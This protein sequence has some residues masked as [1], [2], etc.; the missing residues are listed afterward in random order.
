MK[1]IVAVFV[2]FLILLASPSG[3]FTTLWQLGKED[4]NPMDFGASYTGTSTAPGSALAGDDDYYFAG[5]F[6]APILTVSANEPLPRVKRSISTWEPNTRFHFILNATQATNTLRVRVTSKWIWGGFSGGSNFGEHELRFR[7]NGN[8]IATKMIRNNK[9]IVFEANA[10]V[11][12]ANV[13]ANT[14]K[15]SRIGGSTNAWLSMDALQLDIY[16]TALVDADG[17]GLPEWWELD[18]GLSISLAD[19]NADPDG[20]G[21]TNL[22]EMGLS[23]DPRVADSDADGL[24]DGAEM[25]AGTNPLDK[26]TDDDQLL[27]GWELAQSPS[28]NPLSADSDLDGAADSWEI[29]CGFSATNASSEPPAFNA[30]IGVHFVSGMSESS[31]LL[32]NHVSGWV[33]QPFWNA[34]RPLVPWSTSSGNGADVASPTQGQLVDSSGST[35]AVTMAW[36]CGNAW[37]TG[38]QQSPLFDGYL[39]NRN[40]AD[41]TLALSNIPYTN[42][43]LVVY[44]GSNADNSIGYVRVNNQS[45]TDFYFNTGSTAPENRYLVGTS[46]NPTRP[47]R[48]NVVVFRNLT[49]SSCF[50]QWFRTSYYTIGLHGFQIINRAQD[51]D[52]DGMPDWWEFQHQ[53]HAQ[54]ASDASTDADNDGWSNLVEF[55]NGTSPRIADTDND[56]II[57]SAE[58]QSNPLLADTD[59]DGLSDGAELAVKPTATNP[60]L[61][62]TDGDGR[63]D[64][65]EVR[66]GTNPTI[67]NSTTD[68]LPVVTLSP[69]TFLWRIDN[70]QLVWNHDLSHLAA[71]EWND[72]YLFSSSI[73]NSSTPDAWSSL[74]FGIRF[75]SGKIVHFFYSSKD[76]AFS[77]ANAPANDIWESDW[78]AVT[79]LRSMLGF[80]GVGPCDISDRLRIELSGTSSGSRSAWTIT[81]RLRNLD[82]NAEVVITRNN[83]TLASNVH[84]N[85]AT[86]ENEAGVANRVNYNVNAGIAAHFQPTRLE[87]LPA[88]AAWA[89]GDNDGM[90]NSWEEQ[91]GLNAAL[92]GD[93]NLDADGDGLSNLK[94]FLAHTN[95]LLRDTDGDG[96]PDLVEVQYNSNPLLASSKPPL[97]MGAQQPTMPQDWNG[98]GIPDPW[99]FHYKSWGLA[100]QADQDGDGVS[101][102][103]ESLAGTN[104][105]DPNSKLYSRMDRNGTQFLLCWPYLAHKNATIES[106][107]SLDSGWSTITA[108]PVRNGAE[109]EALMPTSSATKNFY[110]VGVSD[111]DTDQD[112]VSDWA[113][114][115]VLG[116]SISVANSMRSNQPY[117]ANGDGIAESNV[118]GDR[119]ALLQLLEGGN[120]NGGYAGGTAG[121]ISQSNAARFL[122]QSSFGPTDEDVRMVQNLGFSGW[123][124]QQISLPPT[125]HSTYA[126]EINDD[127]FGPRVHKNY[128][129]GDTFLF[130][131]NLQ[132]A[133]ARAAIGSEDQ[134]RQR[135]AF[136]LSQILVASRRDANLE[137]RVLGMASFYDIFVRHALGNYEDILQEVA[138]HPCMGRYLSH[139]GNQKAN[140]EINQYPDENFARE[141]MQLFTIGLWKL[142]PDGTRQIGANG[143]T[144]PTYSNTDITQLARVFTGLWYSNHAWGNGGWSESDFTVPM[145]LHPDRHDFGTK[146]LLGGAIIPSRSAT[147]ENARKDIRDAISLLFQHENTAPFVSRQLIQFLVTDNPTPA[148]VQRVASVFINNGSGK[149]GDLAAV[150]RAILLDQEARDPAAAFGLSF[151]RLKEPIL[152]TMALARV[153][154]MKQHEDLLWWDWND[155]YASSRQE[156][157]YS[158]SVFN[159]YRPD[160]R[161]PGLLTQN[162]LSSPVFQITDSFSSIAFPN[163]IWKDIS[164]GFRLW[165]TY[166]FPLDLSHEVSLASNPE[167]L[168]NRLNVMFCGG[169]M[170]AAT[171][172]TILNA[173]KTIPSSQPEA[174]ARVALYLTMVSAEGAVMR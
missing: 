108:N 13:G 174:R 100:P 164:E 59:G 139:L 55:T 41:G 50:L 71:G 106:S 36:T 70:L 72:D 34:T 147:A 87:S 32:A 173:L 112:G 143:Q 21:L 95:P 90:T 28:L 171:R 64:A 3:A 135:V 137:N 169:H 15:V 7:I 132:T 166:Q 165:G 168:L 47:Q 104:P 60:Q 99:E 149:R 172:S 25:T 78:G 8:T 11:F 150:V 67:A 120:A 66:D 5:N 88:F 29:K 76:G 145:G 57:D 23:T 136:A 97:S 38:N 133:F 51:G 103:N 61:T 92:A 155:Y 79:D 119:V 73:V 142:N 144:I 24:H 131:N 122:I 89:D 20:D 114:I 129:Y 163:R 56:G 49:G 35:T 113:E 127:F 31:A 6:P 54:N 62:D 105:F 22:Q 123:I 53:L 148:Y 74:R 116:S 42:Y 43:D 110:R 17:D 140:P 134:L 96:S 18:R 93:A 128:S 151:G 58:T 27:D 81:Y 30:A 84:Q 39:E 159:F 45:S 10:G 1:N 2:T 167:L 40:N 65:D 86:W 160:Y 26:D 158:P 130:G 126:R 141:V 146:T 46:S 82:T 52:S 80:S 12:S 124:D 101:N 63:S 91:Y 153:C 44:V 77:D 161:A 9:S 138:L 162:Q 115:N 111:V 75:T 107:S 33:P 83:C 16:P 125:L 98:N 37:F 69:R 152:R 4:E 14:L 68:S 170:S 85:T 156:P 102:L 157:T 154:G 117:D 94:E 118:S 48:C 121:G 19:G 109:N